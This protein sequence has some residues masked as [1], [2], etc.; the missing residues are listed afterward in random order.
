MAEEVGKKAAAPAAP[1][2][3][4]QVVVELRL[5]FPPAEGIERRMLGEMLV[6]DRADLV[7][8]AFGGGGFLPGVQAEAR[9]RGRQVRDARAGAE[10]AD[11]EIVVE[12][13]VV[14]GVERADLFPQRAPEKNL[15]LDPLASA[16]PD[17]VDVE[18]LGERFDATGVRAGQRAVLVDPID[19]AIDEVDL[20]M[21]VE[22]IEDA[23]G[24]VLGEQIVAIAGDAEE[25]LF[26]LA[27]FDDRAGAP[28]AET[29]GVMFQDGGFIGKK[30]PRPPGPA[31]LLGPPGPR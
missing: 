17:A 16:P 23:P 3:L 18:H 28:A 15:G 12:G 4:I 22:K 7:G 2:A 6:Q 21:C 10:A 20:G 24:G 31:P 27:L 25:P 9:E 1:A 8:G 26:Q 29:R 11:P 14:G 13:E 19:G 5:D 30:R